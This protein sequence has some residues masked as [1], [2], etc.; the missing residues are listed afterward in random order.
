[1]IEEPIIITR[2]LR[3]AYGRRVAVDG[4]DL[5]VRSGSICGLLG[6]N[7]SGK[8]TALKML[9][10]IT[11]PDSGEGRV[12]GQRIN[13][14]QESLAI[15]ARTGFLPEDKLVPGGMTVGELIRFTRAFYPLWRNDLE[16]HFLRLFHLPPSMTGASLSKGARC[17]LSLVLALSRGAELLVLDE[18]TSGLDP[19]MSEQ[20]LRSLVTLA[21]EGQTTVLFSSHQISEVEQIAD[22]VCMISRGRAVLSEEMDELAN[23][24]QQV[25]IVFDGKPPVSEF[26]NA[27][28]EGRTLSMLV[29]GD[30]E[31]VVARG[32]AM[33]ALSVDVAPAT[34]KDIFL[35]ETS[36][37]VE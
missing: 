15:R 25:R 12:F 32:R 23:T 7:G 1:M 5:E 20:V 36:E 16:E 21:G 14:N 22:R 3:K 24:Y 18:P 19:A 35:T 33:H 4:L 34:L 2:K 28:E 29:R 37:A 8:T 10:G 17:Q 27:R 31:E 13:N 9:M 11:R 6:R 26:D 30:V